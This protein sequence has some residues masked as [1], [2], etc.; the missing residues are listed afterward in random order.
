MMGLVP[1]SEEDER[2]EL[3]FPL[4]EHIEKVIWIHSKMLVV[5]KSGRGPSP[6]HKFAGIFIFDL[7]V[8]ASRIMRN[9]CLI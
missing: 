3:F 4:L 6:K 8:S 9:K 5:C 7:D 2:P 1:L